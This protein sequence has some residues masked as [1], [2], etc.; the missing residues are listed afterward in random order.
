MSWGEGSM[1]WAELRD[2]V[3]ALPEDSATKAASTGDK[4]GYRWSQQ[5]YLAATT[6]NLLQLIAQTLWKAHL[7]GD[8][9]EMKPVEPPKLAA[10]EE[11]DQ[12]AEARAARNRALLDSLRPQQAPAD[13]A[14][15]QA[16]TQQWLARIRE[17]EAAKAAQ[18]QH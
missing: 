8:P 13:T 11:R 15:K 12:L 4:D 1:N 3:Q 14:R 7:K 6:V 5:T 17:L 18:P 16:E 9:P 10:D 2:L